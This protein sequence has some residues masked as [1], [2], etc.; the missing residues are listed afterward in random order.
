MAGI[1]AQRGVENKCSMLLKWKVGFT[2]YQNL[3]RAPSFLT[4]SEEE[5]LNYGQTTK[6]V[7][8]LLEHLSSLLPHLTPTK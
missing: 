6:L 5:G 2:C 7:S 3:Q 1:L 8:T 4:P